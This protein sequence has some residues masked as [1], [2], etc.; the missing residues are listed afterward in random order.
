MISIGEETAIAP[1]VTILTTSHTIGDSDRRAGNEFVCL[2]VTIGRGCW[3]GANVLILPGCSIA[4]G[5]VIA[6]GAV[7]TKNCSE[8]NMLYAG[9]TAKPIRDLSQNKTAS[10]QGVKSGR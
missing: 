8:P 3:I 10:H 9:A 7:V 2:P 1:N 6:A 4:N 5:C